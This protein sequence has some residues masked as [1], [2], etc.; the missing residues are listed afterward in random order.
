MLAKRTTP[1]QLSHCLEYGLTI[2]GRDVKKVVSC[3]QCNFCVYGGRNGDDIGRKR[4]QTESIYLF[5]PPYSPELYYKHLE[6]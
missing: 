1:F 6:K 5:T 4:M 3:V 2:M